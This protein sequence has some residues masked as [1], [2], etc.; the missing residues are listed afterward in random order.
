MFMGFLCGIVSQNFDLGLIFIDAFK[1]L[2]KADL[3]TSE[4]LFKRLETISS[5]HSVDFV[6]SI[7]ED[8]EEL[9]EFIKKYVQQ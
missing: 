9:P 5:N 6:L 7:S 1:K 4:W 3:S 8:E 2:F